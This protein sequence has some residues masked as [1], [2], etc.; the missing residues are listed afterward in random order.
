MDTRTIVEA[1]LLGLLEGLTEFIPVSSTGHILLAG[2][3]LGFESTGKVFEV[4]IQ[5]GAILAILSVYAG[6]IFAFLRRPDAVRL[7]GETV[8]GVLASV[9]WLGGCAWEVA[10]ATLKRRRPNLFLP[11]DLP[12]D[13][14]VRLMVGV[15]LA[16]LPAAVI[17]VLAHD[18]IKTV[19]FETPKLIC[20]M[21]ILGGIVLLWIDR[22]DLKPRYHDAA[23]LPL[24]ACLKIGLFQCLA[25]IPGTSR[26]GATIVGSLL[27]GV[28][29]RAAAEF[30]FFLAVPTML[31][32]FTLDLFKN[33]H[34]L[35][36]ADFPVIAVGFVAAFVAAIIV[37][38]SLLGYVSRHGYSLF[39]WWRL[40]VGGLG[41]AALFVWG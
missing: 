11:P 9:V 37:V 16:F 3:F 13:R 35:S 1:L 14:S 21:L 15:V 41:L 22:L 32:A 4:L 6:K 24:S 29:K 20:V 10:V 5:L 17:G 2:H 8:V 38:R 18:F 36:A 34:I 28:D 40:A 12:K 30:S 7:L 25:M 26:S 19:L 27:M 39:G 23:E 31:G 33:R